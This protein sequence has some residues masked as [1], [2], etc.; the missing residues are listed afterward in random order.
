M[1]STNLLVLDRSP[2]SAERINSLLRNSGIKIHVIHVESSTELK[3]ALDQDSPVLILFANP[4]PADAS[5]EEVNQLA[6]A[7]N[8]TLALF[9]TLE[10]PEE[11][12]RSLSTTACFVINASEDEL[13]IEAVSRLVRSSEGERN[14]ESLK[15]YLEE[16]E[17][18]YN[19]LLDSSR[20]AI[21]YVHEGLHV[22]TNRAYL[23]AMGLKDGTEAAGLSL[24]EMLSAG[25]TNL[26][27]FFKGLSKGHFPTSPL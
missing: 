24:L 6:A 3:R 11:L 7:F 8:I 17:H 23:E 14:R 4:D 19:L 27:T 22:Y 10:E 15:A 1:H 12:A 18:R 26:K 13:L 25:E 16:L 5:L 21:A 2:E 20:D 9:D